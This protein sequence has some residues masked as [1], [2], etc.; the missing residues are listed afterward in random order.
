MILENRDLPP[1]EEA[2]E[3]ASRENSIAQLKELCDVVFSQRS[4]ILASN[5]GPVEHHMTPEGHPEARRGSGSV[6]TAFS[7]LSQSEEFTW[8]ASAMGE[9]TG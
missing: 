9:E 2:I 4:L 7:F 3:E 5:R 1:V 8:V 6:V